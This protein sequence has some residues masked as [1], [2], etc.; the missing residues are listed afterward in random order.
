MTVAHAGAGITVQFST[1][2]AIPVI[3]IPV[4]PAHLH[5]KLLVGCV[6][7]RERR[8]HLPKRGIPEEKILVCD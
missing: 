7:Q 8:S 3:P 5:L 1:V 4:R 2:T 6:G